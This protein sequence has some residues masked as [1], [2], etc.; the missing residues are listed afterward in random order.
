MIFKEYTNYCLDS[1]MHALMKVILIFSVIRIWNVYIIYSV[2]NNFY[3]SMHFYILHISFIYTVKECFHASICFEY[4]S[5]KKKKIQLPNK[6]KEELWNVFP[7]YQEKYTGH[8]RGFL[9]KKGRMR[10]IF[11]TML[12]TSTDSA[13]PRLVCQHPRPALQPLNPCQELMWCV[14]LLL[15]S[16]E[17]IN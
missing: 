6:T 4:H 13:H 10:C 5:K 16:I 17:T 11:R 3:C 12:S 9:W 8:R 2:E 14:S 1:Y 7:N 15:G